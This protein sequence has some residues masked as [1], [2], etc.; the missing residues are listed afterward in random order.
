MGSLCAGAV[1][2]LGVTV[3][4]GRGAEW[5]ELLSHGYLRNDSATQGLI[6]GAV[7]ALTDG[8]VGAYLLAWAYDLFSQS[9]KPTY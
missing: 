3:P 8:F 6:A 9:D 5:G 4:Q 1:G 7:W 2:V